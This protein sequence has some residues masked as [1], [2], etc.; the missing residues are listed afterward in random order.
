MINHEPH[1][2]HERCRRYAPVSLYQGRCPATRCVPAIRRGALHQASLRET[3]S[4]H[5]VCL[6]PAGQLGLVFNF[7]LSV[8]W[9]KSESLHNVTEPF[10]NVDC[11]GF[12][13]QAC[14]KRR[15]QSSPRRQAQPDWN[16]GPSIKTIH[17]K[18]ATAF[19]YLVC[20]V[21]HKKVSKK[22]L[23]NTL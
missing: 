4:P 6:G 5:E 8:C 2:T 7:F 12:I 22:R 16:G 15:D 14:L 17:S 18:R 3:R 20:F 19:E 10:I 21:V 1:E 9:G 23:N 13:G 11:F